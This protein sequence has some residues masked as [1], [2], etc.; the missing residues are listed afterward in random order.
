M[1]LETYALPS[2]CVL[3]LGQEGPGL[4]AEARTACSAVLSVGQYGSTRSINAGAAAAI[5][6]HAWV[7]QHVFAQVPPRGGPG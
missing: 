3:L 4:S 5:A 2:R 6:M 7:R 1:P